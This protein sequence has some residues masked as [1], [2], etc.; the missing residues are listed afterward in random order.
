MKNPIITLDGVSFT[1]KA[2]NNRVLKTISLEIAEDS[3]TG[4]LGPNGVGK[5]TLL[6]LLLG[7]NRPDSGVIKLGGKNIGAYSRNEMGRLIG[8]VP[9]Y[10]HISFEYSILEYVLL[11][12]TPHLNPLQSPGEEDYLVAENAL[13]TVGIK[14]LAGKPVTRLSGG[15][16]Q[17][18]LVARSIAQEPAIL[19]MDEPMS[20]L[21]LANKV[22]LLE[23]MH[24]LNSKGITILFTTHEPDVAA[25]IADSFVLMGEDNLVCSGQADDIINSSSLS[26]IYGI[27]VEVD[28]Y[29][30]RKI[31]IWH[32]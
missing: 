10:E 28:D 27:P 6:H 3:I 8:L 9:Q 16:K 11:G 20:N 1:Y 29:R 14:E 4:I 26:R 18:V 17:L 12:R 13:E 22:R 5:T 23:V 25:S 32:K 2:D 30:G 31:L 7:W 24:S 21:D 15:E 19:L